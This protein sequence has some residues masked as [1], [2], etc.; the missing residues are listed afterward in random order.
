MSKFDWRTDDDIVWDKADTPSPTIRRRR[1]PWIAAAVVLLAAA[2]A[3]LYRQVNKRIEVTTDAVKN[4]ILTSHA[5]VQQAGQQNDDDLFNT[6]VSGRDRTWVAA[7]MELVERGLFFDREALALTWLPARAIPASSA[8]AADGVV[9]DLNPELTAAELTYLQSYATPV[10]NGITETVQL[11]QTA[12]YRRGRRR[13]L[14]SPP[15]DDFWGQLQ[16][17]Q[18]SV[19]V[20]SYPERDAAVAERLAFDLD[21]KLSQMCRSLADLNCPRDMQVHVRLDSEPASLSRS[22]GPLFVLQENGAR[23]ELPAPT[24]IGLPVDEPSYQALYRGYA[25]QIVAATIADLVDYQCCDHLPFFQVL[26][27]HQLA[28]LGLRPFP[29]EQV[30][31]G[32]I[33]SEG[34]TFDD[35]TADWGSVAVYHH[36]SAEGWRVFTAVD[37]IRRQLPGLSIPVLQRHI[38]DHDALADWLLVAARESAN[39]IIDVPAA[40]AIARSWPQFAFDQVVVDQEPPP[41]PFPDQ[42]VFALCGADFN[43]GPRADLYQFDLTTMTW[44]DEPLGI[45]YLML[46]PLP[47][48]DALF[49]QSLDLEDGQT[50]RSALLRDGV[51]EAL[52]AGE[53]ISFGQFDPT[54]ERMI[55]YGTTQDS[56]GIFLVDVAACQDGVCPMQ[57][58]AGTPLWSPSGQDFIMTPVDALTKSPFFVNDRIILFDVHSPL[59]PWPIYRGESAQVLGDEGE[60]IRTGTGFAPFW[61]DESTYGY[62]WQVPTS[63]DSR[64]H[65]LVLASTVDDAPRPLLTEVVLLAALPEAQ[66]AFDF[67]LTLHYVVPHPLQPD[68][69]FVVALDEARQAYVFS[70]HLPTKAIRFHLQVDFSW[71]NSLGFSPDGRFLIMTGIMAESSRDIAPEPDNRIILYDLEANRVQMQALPGSTLFFS[72]MN[73]YDWSADGQWLAIVLDSQALALVAPAYDYQFLI[74]HDLGD[75]SNVAWLNQ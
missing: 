73:L 70:Y 21:A 26:L 67:D 33:V 44:V 42:A 32:R 74:P 48:D 7:Q 64:R 57:L 36:L 60:F 4:D 11:Q 15:D 69:L 45:D 59:T 72:P 50:L 68:L 40:V 17:N 66:R 1:L 56:T 22:A 41:I 25:V 20:L 47:Q 75:C 49:L 34:A 37:Y 28:D 55:A 35:L 29:A 58:L 14:L 6:L 52:F 23:L 54:G 16:A 12:V 2:G 13:W 10:G 5:L 31:Y 19:L 61:L 71:D 18:G 46:N 63:S 3:V 39:T 9:I 65:Q 53:Y 62:I 51:I 27:A 43:E 38:N 30:D 24:L 8:E